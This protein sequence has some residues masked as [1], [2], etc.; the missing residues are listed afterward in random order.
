[1]PRARRALGAI[2]LLAA[3]AGCG[4]DGA[5]PPS[6]PTAP[7][8]QP[9]ADRLDLAY[10]TVPRRL[11]LDLYTPA[12]TPPFP[13]V[14]WIHGGSWV[15]GDRD[16]FPGHPAL[17]L[18][19]RGYAVAT[20]DYRLVPEGFF[21]A[22]SYDCKAAVRWLRGNA[23]T[24]GLDRNSIGAWGASAGGHLAAL[25]GT[26]GGMAELEDLG[27]GNAG[28]SSRVQAVVDWFGPTDYRLVDAEQQLTA[29]LLLGCPIP[30]CPDKAALASPVS[31]V[32]GTDPPFLIQ[33]G[34][35]DRVV[36]IVHSERL[37]GELLAA[38]VG[39]TFTRIEGAGHATIEFLT[40][41]NLARIDAFLDAELRGR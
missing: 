6:E 8:P 5:S 34:T 41:E 18:R 7:T 9:A 36:P 21:P 19:E 16:I 38:A 11:A 37:H 39:S 32:D 12:G 13:V 27:Q 28:E 35:A 24:Y 10:T 22:Q 30:V 14:V 3:L 29:A 25:L 4:E 15:S 20:I 1:M 17:R 23:E 33:H 2:A 40:A 31:H 26:S